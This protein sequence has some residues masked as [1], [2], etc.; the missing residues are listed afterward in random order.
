MPALPVG[1]KRGRD[2]TNRLHV[3]FAQSAAAPIGNVARVRVYSLD[4]RGPET[5]QLEKH[6][7]GWSQQ[8]REERVFG[9]KWS[10]WHLRQLQPAADIG[11][12]YEARRKAWV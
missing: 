9:R 7:M 10:S 8:G 4:F 3:Q 2:L 12:P 11:A 5:P 6:W 1:E